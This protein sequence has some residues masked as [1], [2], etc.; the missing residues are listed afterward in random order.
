MCRRRRGRLCGLRDQHRHQL[1]EGAAHSQGVWHAGAGT[2][3]THTTQA[4][5]CFSLLALVLTHLARIVPTCVALQ[6]IAVNV[7]RATKG[8]RGLREELLDITGLRNIPVRPSPP[9]TVPNAQTRGQS[10]PPLCHRAA[11]VP[12]AATAGDL[13]R[14]QGAHALRG[15]PQQAGHLSHVTESPPLSVC[16]YV[17]MYLSM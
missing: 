17:S 3:N 13:R 4:G 10:S 8:Y 9:N 2:T 7:D 11:C 15:G 6:V 12:C 5:V 16:I 14:A 1:C